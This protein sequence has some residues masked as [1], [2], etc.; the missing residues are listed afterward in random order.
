[1]RT[2]AYKVDVASDHR[3]RENVPRH[4]LFYHSFICSR[5]SYRKPDY[6]H[7]S[8]WSQ[9]VPV[10]SGVLRQNAGSVRPPWHAGN[11]SDLQLQDLLPNEGCYH[12]LTGLSALGR[13]R[14]NNITQYN[15]K[16]K[17]AILHSSSIFNRIN[18]KKGRK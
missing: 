17:Q 16:I 10:P 8:S 14:K 15:M 11:E 3:R 1:M 18:F 9:G 2:A 7:R 4:I 5:S 12:T 13:L 6:M